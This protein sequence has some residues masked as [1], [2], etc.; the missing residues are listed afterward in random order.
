MKT[1]LP[2]IILKGIVL[3]PNND[4][5]LEF[6]ND[7]SKNIVDISELFHDNKV[8]VVS[9][10]NLLEE[11]PNIDELEKYGVVSKI[12]HK[13]ELPNGK[14]RVTITGLYRAQVYEYLN[15][16]RADD[17]LESIISKSDVDKIPDKEEKAFTRK[18]YREME[19]YIKALPYVSNSVL[20]LI[21]NV[22]SLDK[23]TDIIVPYLQIDN[24]RT[25]EYL[26]TNSSLIRLEMIL[27]DIYSEKEMFQIEKELDTKVRKEM[28]D[29]Q[30]EYIL[31]EKIKAIKQELGDTSL[32]EVEIEELKEKIQKIKAPE[33]IK[34]K[35]ENELKRYE[36]LTASSP[37]V[38][39]TRSYIDWLIDLPW[40]K[41]TIDNDD[42]SEVR[43]KL[44]ESHNGLEK[45]KTRIIEYLAVKQMSGN[46]KSPIICL[47]GPPGVGKT[48]LAFSISKAMN[49]NFV[50]ISVGG[51]TDE[52]EL[53]GHRRTYIGANPGRIIS[54]LKKAKSMNP[55]FLIDEIDKMACSYKGDP[56]STMLEILDPEQN[57]YF[58]DNYIE[59][60]FDLSKVMFIATANNID[61]IP[62]PLRDRLEIVILSGYTEY[63]KLD[64][65]RK[66]LLPKICKEHGVN[67]KGIDIKDEL[68]LYIIR[69][70]TKEAGVRELERQLSNII[71]KIVASIVTKHILVNKVIVD[72]KK[73]KEYLGNTK[74]SFIGSNKQ[75]EIGVVNGLAYTH[76]GGDV[77]PIEINCFKGSGN[78]VL[79]G[80]L[81]KV[82]KESAIIALNY[83]KSNYKY[84][85]IEYDKLIN[86]DIHIHVPEGA[87]PKDGPS[88]GITLVTAIISLF[89]NLKINKNIAMTGEITLRGKV[90]PIGG[91]KEKSIGA[92]RNRI[93]TII[94]PYDNLK[95]LD[96]I[97]EE[98]KKDIN[99]IPVKTYR[100]VIKYLKSTKEKELVK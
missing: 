50:K 13:M 86:N 52:A 66:Y 42:L 64:I 22:T 57:K 32:K 88:A 87:I 45:V 43:K 37:E 7:D 6:E 8:L 74:Y 40:G 82:M 34:L 72:K 94:I 14:V 48:T 91:L 80:S 39:T 38:N 15:K 51:I 21:S 29:N 68:L 97:P 85:H 65:A 27:E 83:I 33:N 3:L 20:A 76:F 81:G 16:N 23:M 36:T 62:E 24:R 44:D 11:M 58:S 59:E 19:I 70:Y 17:I 30:K 93:S 79:T 10:I 31:R 4:I 63:E 47:V 78:L 46:L 56:A 12:S 26:K 41:Y 73:I 71:R 5:R 99:Y 90:L 95:D 89:T 75:S 35:L 60:E 98:I 28:E 25:I 77:L 18:L 49:R 100:D 1:N 92:H 96:E 69:Y 55:I 61:D 9:Q 84:F 54:S 67:V 53:I 2:V